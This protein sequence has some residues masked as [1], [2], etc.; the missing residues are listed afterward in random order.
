MLLLSGILLIL[1]NTVSAPCNS[2][3]KT[4]CNLCID[5]KTFFKPFFI[6]NAICIFIGKLL[7]SFIFVLLSFVLWPFYIIALLVGVAADLILLLVF[8]VLKFIFVGLF[9]VILAILFYILPIAVI[10]V[11][12][13]I[14][15]KYLQN[16]DE[17]N[18]IDFVITI[19]SVIGTIAMCVLY[20]CH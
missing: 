10:V 7:Q 2:F 9:V 1:S 13:I 17:L 19:I 15:I 18:A 5:G 3:F 14:A 11:S 8:Y 16:A 12:I 20:Y 4:V 6:C